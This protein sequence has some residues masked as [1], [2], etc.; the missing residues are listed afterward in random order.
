MTECWAL[1]NGA[2][3]PLAD[4]RVSPLDRAY[5]FGD[6]VYEVMRLYDGKI[7]MRGEHLERLRASL[8]ALMIGADLTG[9]SDRLD[10]LVAHA[11]VR[12]AALYI[13][14][15]RG[16]AKRSHI[17]PAGMRPNELVWLEP[18]P[19]DFGLSKQEKGVRVALLPDQ[20]WHLA[21]IKTVNLLGNV[22]AGMEAKARGADEALLYDPV[23]GRVTEGMHS[24]F[25]AVKDGALITTPLGANILPGITRAFVLPLARRLGLDVTERS[26]ARS[27]LAAMDEMFFTGTLS[28]IVP[29]ISLDGRAIGSGV[30]GPVTRRLLEAA[31]AVVKSGDP[32]I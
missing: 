6:A 1:W 3:L 32:G 19:A 10:R 21:R 24:T 31:I 25:F 9:L 16:E 11:N 8:E 17:P 29:I 26:L 15:S 7:F 18:L 5:L 30:P 12:E 14:I 27:E 20:R 13:Q 4:V 22:L 2:L 28:E 23:D